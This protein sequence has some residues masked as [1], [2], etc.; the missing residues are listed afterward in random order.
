MLHKKKLKVFLRKGSGLTEENDKEGAARSQRENF[1]VSTDSVEDRIGI[2]MI[3]P[4]IS[5]VLSRLPRAFSNF[6]WHIQVWKVA[7]CCLKLVLFSPLTQVQASHSKGRKHLGVQSDSPT[8]TG[9]EFF[10]GLWAGA[11]YT[12]SPGV[13]PGD[14]LS[15]AFP[16]APLT[17]P[18]KPPLGHPPRGCWSRDLPLCTGLLVTVSS[19]SLPAV[20]KT[21]NWENRIQ[22]MVGICTTDIIMCHL[23]TFRYDAL[24]IWWWSCTI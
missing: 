11:T 12:K 4:Y 20:Q 8:A 10:P 18:L 19:E 3:T 7:G 2:V 14:G 5:W 23:M 6:H 1:E 24:H 21:C 15:G 16:P 9:Q 17:V 22:T 13:V